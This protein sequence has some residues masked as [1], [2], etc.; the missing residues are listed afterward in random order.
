M[1]RWWPWH[2]RPD[3]MRIVE[4]MFRKMIEEIQLST[5]NL[6]KLI[7]EQK[8]LADLVAGEETTI[9]AN[10]A[11][12]TQLTTAVQADTTTIAD[13]ATTI[14]SLT[15]QVA[16]LKAAQPDVDTSSLEASIAK[17][18]ELNTTL[19]NNNAAAAAVLPSPAPT[20]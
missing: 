12:I 13:Q 6:Q 2:R 17:L 10:T 11:V 8:T 14:G 4:V 1:P 3:P 7:D 5:A 15:Q 20:A 18:T 16:D 19:S 9:A